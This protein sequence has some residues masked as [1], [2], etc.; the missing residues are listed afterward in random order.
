MKSTDRNFKILCTCTP[1]P[2]HCNL[3]KKTAGLD[4]M[5][6]LATFYPGLHCQS[7]D[8]RFPVYKGLK[9]GLRQVIDIIILAIRY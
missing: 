1:V 7:T 9:Y 6:W 8:L 2:N 3:S 5:S 4:Q